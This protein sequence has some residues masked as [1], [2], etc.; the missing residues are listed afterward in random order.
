MNKEQL[1]KQSVDQKK[2][3]FP[4]SRFAEKHIIENLTVERRNPTKPLAFNQLLNQ[5]N[6]R[7][8]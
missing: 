7:G 4:K 3:F 5:G 2:Q 1:N 8:K 6:K